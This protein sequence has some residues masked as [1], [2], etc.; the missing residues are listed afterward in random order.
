MNIPFTIFMFSTFHLFGNIAFLQ[1]GADANANPQLPFRN[2]LGK[3]R[4]HS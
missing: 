4:E 1:A 3:W 2:Q